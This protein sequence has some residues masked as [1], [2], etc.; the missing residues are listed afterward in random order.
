MFDPHLVSVTSYSLP[1]QISMTSLGLPNLVS[2]TIGTKIFKK[3]FKKGTKANFFKIFT[4]YIVILRYFYIIYVKMSY[5][6]RVPLRS[7]GTG[8]LSMSINECQRKSPRGSI[9]HYHAWWGKYKEREGDVCPYQ[10]SPCMKGMSQWKIIIASASA[11]ASA[12]LSADMS[13]G[14][15]ESSRLF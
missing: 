1:V 11:D 15:S 4:M 5:Q 6:C 2:V 3:K 10:E 12:D 8:R 7:C 9:A 14:S 13:E